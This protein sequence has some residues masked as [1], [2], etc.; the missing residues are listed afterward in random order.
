M[1]MLLLLML[2]LCLPLV[3]LAQQKQ[4]KVFPYDYKISDL[5]NGLRVVTVPTDYPNLVA[6]YI[7]VST[8]SRNEIEPGKSGYAHLFEHLMFR[9]SENYSAEQ[10]DAILKRAGAASNAYTSDDRTVYH[11]VFSKE[12]LEEIM[13]MEADRFMRLKYPETA[14]KTETGAVRG[15]YDK[16]SSNPFSQLYERLRET[17]FQKHTYSH[18]TMGYL[19]DIVDMPNQYQYSLDFYR[20]YYRPEYTTIVLVGDVTPER[21]LELAKK[22]FGEWKRGNYVPEIQSEPEQSAPRTAYVDWPTPT[23]PHLAVAFRAPAFSDERKDKAALDLLAVVAFGENSDLYQRL[24]LKE[25][26]VDYLAVSFDDQV[27]PEM[28]AVLARVKDQKNLEDVREQILSTFKRYSTETIPQAKLDATR[29]RLRYSFALSMN[30]SQ[31]IAAALAPYIALRR[32]PEAIDRVYALYEQITPEDIRAAA[33]RYFQE[34]NRTIV[35]L[36]T[37]NASATSAGKEGEK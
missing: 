11:E 6:L 8:G 3:G 13:K 18:T 31:A 4:R 29:S 30:S 26:K 33:A 2:A 7:V 35:T 20:R 24:V 9:G 25:Q 16:N 36:A 28:F 5:P 15:E 10:R 21:S 19:K 27:D 14:Y 1:K 22:Y 23:L 32:T 37:K 12:D 34:R 17:A